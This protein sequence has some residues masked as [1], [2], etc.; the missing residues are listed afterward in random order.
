MH[1]PPRLVTADNFRDVAGPGAGY[2][3]TDGGH[4]RPGVLYRSNDL[5]LSAEDLLVLS[6]MGLRGVL[7]LRTRDEIEALP[8]AVVPGAGW[9]H[10]DVSGIPMDDALE[11]ADRADAEA[12]MQRVYRG[13]VE[14]VRSRTQ[15][16]AFL[17]HLATHDGPQLFHCTTGKD[18]SGWAA[19]LLLHVAGV[20]ED[21]I[22]ADYLL[23]ND[24]AHATRNRYLTMV[25]A[26]FGADRVAVFEPLFVADPGYLDTAYAAVATSYGD[27]DAYLSA[28]L[29]LTD[30]AREQLRRRL[31]GPA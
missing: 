31:R 24:Y 23:T 9:H 12:L 21:V 28:G 30:A 26:A 19:A 3:T 25:E 16:G 20:A 15:Y 27:L 7:D 14:D 17:T 10:F 18:R 1:P 29:G 13:F 2:P 11:L 5:Q 4:V 22:L 6:G 8:D